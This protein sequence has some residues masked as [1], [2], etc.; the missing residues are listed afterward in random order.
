MRL[1]WDCVMTSLKYLFRIFFFF[2]FGKK[3]LQLSWVDEEV[4]SLVLKS[5]R[6]GFGSGLFLS[7]HMTLDKLTSFLQALVSSSLKRQN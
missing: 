6:P 5:G 7:Q 3:P 1:G 4:K 2:K